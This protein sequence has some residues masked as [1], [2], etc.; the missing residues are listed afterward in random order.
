VPTEEA[1]ARIQ[2]HAL[3]AIILGPILMAGAGTVGYLKMEQREKLNREQKQQ[4]KPDPFNPWGP[5]A[6]VHVGMTVDQMIAIAG[7]ANKIIQPD[8]EVYMW[9]PT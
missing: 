6:N 4:A 1:L 2:R 9:P 5:L 7:P 3:I 8:G